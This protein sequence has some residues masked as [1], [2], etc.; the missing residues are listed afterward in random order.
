MDSVILVAQV[1]SLVG[2][3][4]AHHRHGLKK[5]QQALNGAIRTT[6]PSKTNQD[7]SAVSTPSRNVTFKQIICH[8]QIS[9]SEATCQITDPRSLPE[10][11]GRARENPFL[12]RSYLPAPYSSFCLK[13][14]F[15]WGNPSS[16]LGSCWCRNHCMK[17]TSS[18]NVPTWILSSNTTVPL[19]QAGVPSA[20][21]N[22]WPLG[23]ARKT[24][25]E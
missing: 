16:P 12:L 2:E 22:V 3:T 6:A 13:K 23:G 21:S 1:Q 5:K 4:S 17:Q 8:L 10:R 7:V 18:G 24:C 9:G 14:T 25:N 11:K 19:L 20:S 15:V